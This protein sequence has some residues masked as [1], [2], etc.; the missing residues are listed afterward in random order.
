MSL[1]QKE[2]KGFIIMGLVTL[3]KISIE[4]YVVYF[5]V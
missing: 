3:M 2:K 1:G 4:L 5:I